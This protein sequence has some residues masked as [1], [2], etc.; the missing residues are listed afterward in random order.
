MLHRLP[1]YDCQ[2]GASLL[3]SR[4]ESRRSLVGSRKGLTLTEVMVVLA[5]LLLL[6]GIMVP[7]AESFFMLDQRKAGK[8][9][10]LLYEQLHDEAVM[11][12]V[13]FRVAYNLRQDT[14]EVQV[15]ESG[16][17]IFDNPR[18]REEFEETLNR[19][20]NLMS[21]EEKAEFQKKRKNFQTL[22]TRFKTKFEMPS[23][24]RIGGVY[25]PQYEE[26]QT[27][28][29][30]D[31][32]SDGIIY[33]YIFPNGQAEHA[34]VWIVDANDP[35]DGFTI[36]IEPLSGSVHL[37]GELIDWDDSYDWVPSEAPSLPN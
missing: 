3:P 28:D 25:T 22:S 14:Y 1:Q 18:A 24:A 9:L 21:D 8:E 35:E 10:A 30:L 20:T 29:D 15:A 27:L 31:E 33:S 17:L 32:D 11:R 26:M 5:I 19:K 7:S 23:S 34:V 37:H 2:S 13:T 12:N 36:E 6:V 4:Q 16:A